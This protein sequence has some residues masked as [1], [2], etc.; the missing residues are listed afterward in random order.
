MYIKVMANLVI[1]ES[2]HKAGT[3]KNFLG[4]NYKVLASKGH[5]RDLP[6]STLGI[7]I[8]NNF[9]PKYINIRGKGDLIRELQKEAKAADK[10]FLATDPDREGEAIA[11]HL[12]NALNIPAEKTKRVTF[13]EI[14]KATVKA[15][16]KAPRDIDMAVVNSQQT[17]R[18]LDR[19][20]G[21][22]LSPFLWKNIKSGLSAGRVQSVATR[23]IAEREEEINSFV[24]REYWSIDVILINQN[25]EKF[26]A[27]FIGDA[28]GKIELSD[29]A[30]TDALLKE[31]NLEGFKVVSIKNASKIKNPAAPFTTSTMQQ[32]ASKRLGFQSQKIMHVA[33]ELY[34]GVN[35]GSENG[36]SQGLIT[37]MRTDSLRISEE[38]AEAAREFIT[39]K[40]GDKF[41]PATKRV[42]K[43]KAGAQDAHE[44]IRPSNPFLEPD[45]I[46]KYL[47]QDQ[48]KLYKLIWS[49]FI[50]SQMASSVIDTVNVDT[51]DGKY[52]FHSSGY[53]VKFSGYMAVYTD[54]DDILDDSDA[55]GNTTALPAL[56]EGEALKC[57]DMLPKQHFTEP[58][59]RFNEASLIKILEEKGIGRPSTYTPI[60]T[61]IISRGYVERVGK[62]LKITNLGDIT[63]KM[64]KESFPEIIDY[65]FTANMENDLDN[66]EKGNSDYHAV[67]ADF[68]RDFKVSLE[69]AESNTN[70]TKVEL[71]VEETDIICDKCGSRMIIK[72]G[73][74]GKFAACPNYPQCKNTKPLNAKK[75]PEDEAAKEAAKT[76]MKCELCGADMV[77]RSGRYGSFYACSRYPECKNT[78]RITKEI[79]VPCPKC[80][81]KIAIRRGRNKTVFYSCE[82]YPECD[83]SSWDLPLAEKCPD[84]GNILYRKKGKGQII[85]HN[86]DCSYKR[87]PDA[88]ETAA[89]DE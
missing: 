3:V 46:K 35:L 57:S 87:E 30:Q 61:T 89:S 44:A 80:G 70:I 6:K 16:I 81:S 17:R 76:D 84:C 29:K 65:D 88:N 42:Y 4:S 1:L 5:V 23:I 73:R 2:P 12:A 18:I 53:S 55:N 68:Y 69:K 52:L 66:I 56:S 34:E 28:K 83:F 51:T 71:P 10:V 62:S 8:D 77:L 59:P 9:T 67:L 19:I 33:Q 82:K 37:Y 72:E 47:T 39:Q 15:A 45:K 79:D 64:M 50:A 32:E 26:K 75:K 27:K 40:Y 20:V 38:A 7:D 11:W 78:K 21:Y 60:I 31:I 24:S 48:Y 74:F 58:P 63:T 22:K 25:G 43:A 54:S 49:R 14:N 86:K 85:C 13:N 36:G 41:Y